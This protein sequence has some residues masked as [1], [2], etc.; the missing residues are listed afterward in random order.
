MEP[1]VDGLEK[2]FS[3]LAC[4]LFVN[5]RSKVVNYQYDDDDGDQYYLSSISTNMLFVLIVKAAT[6]VVVWQHLKQNSNDSI[7]I[8][9][10]YSMTTSFISTITSI[11]TVLVLVLV[12][13]RTFIVVRLIE[14]NNF[15]T[16]SCVLI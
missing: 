5:E 12:I 4:C 16:I 3:S 2:D 10:I 7:F 14:V 15:T 6:D 1:F 9:N 8:S 11:T 13:K